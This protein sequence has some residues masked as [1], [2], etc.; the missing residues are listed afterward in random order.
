MTTPPTPP[1]AAYPAAPMPLHRPGRRCSTP[2]A[3]AALP[4]AR[5]SRRPRRRPVVPIRRVR[6]AG[7]PPDSRRVTATEPRPSTFRRTGAVPVYTTA[8]TLRARLFPDP[9][10]LRL[11]LPP[12]RAEYPRPGATGPAPP[13]YAKPEFATMMASRTPS[14]GSTKASAWG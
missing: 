7:R 2:S 5:S 12:G 1:L 4:R 11:G 9:P 10:S 14:T 3:H 13:R 8:G 6:P